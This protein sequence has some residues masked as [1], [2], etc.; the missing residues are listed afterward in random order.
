MH[1][2]KV[3]DIITGKTGDR[4]EGDK[5]EVIRRTFYP[6][7]YTPG[8]FK[9]Y[10]Y[11]ADIEIKVLT[12]PLKGEINAVPSANYKLWEDKEVEESEPITE[13]NI[14]EVLEYN[15]IPRTLY[16]INKY[17]IIINIGPGLV[18]QFWFNNPFWLQLVEVYLGKL[19]PLPK[20]TKFDPKQYLIDNGFDIVDYGE[21]YYKAL[22]FGCFSDD[23]KSFCWD[24]YIYDN[25]QATKE[26]LDLLIQIA[27]LTNQ[28]KKET[29]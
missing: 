24:T 17:D 11:S 6:S 13:S 29:K 5:C 9:R 8:A 12:G 1:K 22:Y 4:Y 14:Q 10:Y 19:K 23:F 28:L 21:I 2:F 26:N 20:T 15:N 16:H 18:N 3:G 25:S 7:I 27:Q